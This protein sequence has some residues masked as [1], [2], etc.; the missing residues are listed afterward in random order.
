VTNG[1]GRAKEE[2]L[3][4]PNRQRKGSNWVDITAKKGGKTLRIN[5]VDMRKNGQM[6]KRERKAA[7][8]IK[9]KTE[10]RGNK[11]LAIPKKKK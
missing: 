2:Y 5:T 3:P 9:Q 11:F 1:G 10:G 6:T 8:K 4:G 7:N